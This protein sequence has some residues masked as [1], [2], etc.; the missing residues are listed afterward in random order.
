M[1]G[2][3]GFS[4][5][6]LLLQLLNIS[7]VILA[8]A[9]TIRACI[10][11]WQRNLAPAAHIFW[12]LTVIFISLVGAIAFFVVQPGRSLNKKPTYAKENGHAMACPFSFA[13]ILLSVKFV[14]SPKQTVGRLT[15]R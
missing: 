15:S 14:V 1:L 12:G 10:Q 7:L 5:A 9:L 6:L 3:L 11:I 4:W 8:F 13:L 2:E